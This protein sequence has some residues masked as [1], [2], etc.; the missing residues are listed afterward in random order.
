MILFCTDA[1]NML[2]QQLSGLLNG[3]FGGIG[4][5]GIQDVLNMN[6][7]QVRQ[8]IIVHDNQKLTLF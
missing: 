7:V 3:L 8:I 2:G 4:K 1:I 5:R 6:V